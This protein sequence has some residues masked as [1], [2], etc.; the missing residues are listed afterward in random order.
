MSNL[1]FQACLMIIISKPDVVGGGKL[2][3]WQLDVKSKLKGKVST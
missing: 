1:D 2:D 3:E